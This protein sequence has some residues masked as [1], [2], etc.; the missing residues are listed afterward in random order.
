M[1]NQKYLTNEASGLLDEIL[2]RNSALEKQIADLEREVRNQDTPAPLPRI[3]PLTYPEPY[4]GQRAI[5]V[6]DEQH[7]WYSNGMWRKGGG[8]SI[9][10]VKVFEEINPVIAGDKAFSVPIPED[11]DAGVL[12][13]V[14]AAVTT[15]S[16][17]GTVQVQLRN[18]MTGFDM[19]TTK[20]SIDVGEK[21]SK[22]AATQPVIDT[23]RDDVSWGDHI[24]I[25][26]DS[27]GTGAKGL[28]LILYFLPSALAALIVA[29]AK[30]DPG[31]VTSWTGQWLTAT[32]YTIGQAVSNNG[33][34]YVARTNHTSSTPSEPGIGASWQTD[35]MLLTEVQATSA[36]QVVVDGNGYVLTTGVKGYVEVPFA[37][38]IVAVRMYADLVGSM[39]VDIWKDTYANFPPL[40]ADSITAS[41]PPTLISVNKSMDTTLSGWTTAL[42][43]G[44][45]LAFNIDSCTFISRVTIALALERI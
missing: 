38:T 28:T 19:L 9:F 4:E 17:S 5:D 3:H 15:V 37:C 27:A 34:S 42:A 6:T 25:D 23:A 41:S 2:R 45:I 11:L 24:A 33:S 39:V 14:E 22:D 20:V 1:A 16:T 7:T 44:D 31:G 32:G 18:E 8:S 10:E 43:I 30:G 12:V 29:G 40:N 26:V 21:N 35:W 13:K 36:I